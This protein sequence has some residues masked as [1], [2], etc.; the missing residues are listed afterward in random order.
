ML[1]MKRLISPNKIAVSLLLI[2]FLVLAIT[3]L[4]QRNTQQWA[5]SGLRVYNVIFGY[6]S[7][8]LNHPSAVA[9]GLK[10]EVFVANAGNRKIMVFAENGRYLYSFSGPGTGL[11]ELKNPVAM[12]VGPNGD[13]YVSDHDRKEVIV[14]KSSGEY[15]Y[16]VSAD[17]PA[18]FIPNGIIVGEKGRVFVVNEHDRNLYTFSSEDRKL[19]KLPGGAK[20]D[21]FN[22]NGDLCWDPDTGKIYGTDIENKQVVVL[23]NGEITKSWGQKYLSTP[24]GIAFDRSRKLVF[25]SDSVRSRVVVFGTDGEYK[26]EFG[27]LGEKK[28]N[29]NFPEGLAMDQRGRL[30]VADRGNNRVIIYEFR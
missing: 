17:R 4:G 18:E 15:K 7:N 26:G 27:S 20:K 13:L 1:E 30:Y 12:A 21:G 8:T 3:V 16:T 19:K 22:I 24:G 28:H 29:F 2:V 25:V 6:G 5:Y 10:G 11:A 14:F 23:Q 9:V